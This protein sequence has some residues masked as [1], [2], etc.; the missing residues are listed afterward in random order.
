MDGAHE[1]IFKCYVVWIF[2][3]AKPHEI[4]VVGVEVL[5]SLISVS[6]PYDGG[7]V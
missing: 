6:R 4:S 2:G 7:I 5:H 3:A 1:R